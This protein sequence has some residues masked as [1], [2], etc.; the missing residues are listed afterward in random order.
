MKSKAEKEAA[1]K[2]RKAEKIRNRKLKQQDKA[3]SPFIQQFSP[4]RRE[5]WIMP[6][7]ELPNRADQKQPSQGG[8]A[9]R[10]YETTIDE[11]YTTFTHS[12]VCHMCSFN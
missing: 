6:G 2:R 3:K 1:R 12:E 11:Y 8:E 7:T 5:V 9:N 4:G 10:T